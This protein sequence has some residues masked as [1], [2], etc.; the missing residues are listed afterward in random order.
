MDI[1]LSTFGINFAMS[2]FGVTAGSAPRSRPAGGRALA[3]A[4]DGSVRQA[5]QDG[6]EILANGNLQSP[7]AFE[8]RQNGCYL[9]P[10]L[11]AAYMDPVLSFMYT[12]T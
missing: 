1:F 9:W 7:A 8:N 11:F 12:C 4:L 5:R 2:W 6:G 3:D 10:R